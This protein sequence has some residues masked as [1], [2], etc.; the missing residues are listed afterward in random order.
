MDCAAGHSRDHRPYRYA[1]AVN[2]ALATIIGVASL[3]LAGWVLVPVLRDR[4]ID[5]Y[6]V[7]AL[8]VLE[9][10]LVAQA[11]LAIVWMAQ[12]NHPTELATFIGYLV[13][14]VLVL[15]LAG[16]LS[17]M[18]RTRWGSII[19]MAGCVVTAVLML[20]LYQVWHG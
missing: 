12:G 9:G 16:V 4:W 10:A 15:P 2:D 13:A 17:F 19:V 14:S 6:H 11:V 7:V 3:A 5:C 8:G 1:R 18:E 20:R